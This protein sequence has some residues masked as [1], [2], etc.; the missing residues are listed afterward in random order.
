MIFKFLDSNAIAYERVDHPA[1]FTCEEA[2]RL[3][4]S[5]AGAE[6]KNLFLRDAKGRRHFLLS[7]P[8]EKNVDLKTLS[9][10]IAVSGLS[11]ASPERLKREIKGHSKKLAT[12]FK[13]KK[14]KDSH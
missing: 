10:I 4:P 14:I 13:I 9:T 8:A 2:K 5:L 7:V 11:L 3:V 1:V 6:T 12:F